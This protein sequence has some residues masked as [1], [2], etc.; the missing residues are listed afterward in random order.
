MEKIK[1]SSRE[2]NEGIEKINNLPQIDWNQNDAAAGDYIKNRT[3]YEHG[4]FAEVFKDPYSFIFDEDACQIGNDTYGNTPFVM[5]ENNGKTFRIYCPAVFEGYKEGVLHVFEYI[6]D[7]C[8]NIPHSIGYIGNPSLRDG[9]WTPDGFIDE[10]TGEDFCLLAVAQCEIS[11]GGYFLFLTDL[12]SWNG[13][14]SDMGFR[15]ECWVSEEIKQLD[16]KF[17]PNTIARVGEGKNSFISNDSVSALSE[18]AHASGF[19]SVSGSKAFKIVSE[20]TDNSDGTGSYILDS[21]NGLD[22][23][24]PYFVNTS[25]KYL[26]GKIINVDKS[27]NTVTVDGFVFYDLQ[28]DSDGNIRADE[29]ETYNVYNY[30]L[31]PTRPD[32]GTISVGFSAEANGYST[33]SLGRA[34]YS[35]GYLTQ[36]LGKSSHAEGEESKAIGFN[37]H[38]EGYQTKA[39]GN[40]SHSEG[41]LTTAS[42][43]RSHAEG[44]GTT[45]SGMR[46][47]AEGSGTIAKGAHQHVQGKYNIADTK[48]AHIIGNG[49]S[50]DSRSNAH[51][52]DWDGNAWYAGSIAIG[53]NKEK[54]L[55][56]NTYKGSGNSSFCENKTNTAEGHYSHAEGN[57]SES[58]G[59]YSHAEGY[60][61]SAGGVGSH[62]EGYE[63]QT[64][65]DRSHAEGNATIASGFA[66]HAEGYSTEASGN[67]SHAE[68]NK[69]VASGAKSHAEGNETKASGNDSHAEGIG[70][71]ASAQGAHAEGANTR[72]FGNFSHA[73]GTG[74]IASAAHQHVQGKY[75]KEV[76]NMVHIVGNG[77]SDENR[78]N[79]HTLDWEGNAWY[80]G[81][82]TVGV[83]KKKLLTESD[84]DT[85][86]WNQYDSTAPDYIKNRT[87]YDKKTEIVWSPSRNL[88]FHMEDDTAVWYEDYAVRDFFDYAKY[89]GK[90]LR[91]QSNLLNE[92]AV[93]V[94]TY[95]SYDSN[96][97]RAWY[98]FS[99]I[100][101]PDKVHPVVDLCVYAP[102]DYVENVGFFGFYFQEY[103]QEVLD[104]GEDIYI[105][106]I[107]EEGE[108]KQLDEKFIPDTIAR[109]SD[110]TKVTQTTGDSE[111]AVMSQKATTKELSRLSQICETLDMA[112]KGNI[113]KDVTYRKHGNNNS[114]TLTSTEYK[115]IL[116]Y[117]TI[118]KLESGHSTVSERREGNLV[119][120]QYYY[121][122]GDEAAGFSITIDSLKRIVLDGYNSDTNTTLWFVHSSA[123][124]R[125]EPDVYY[126]SGCPYNGG[127]EVRLKAIS[128]D[129]QTVAQW[130][131][132]GYGVVCDLR[133]ID[134]YCLCLGI[135]I[136]ESY[137][138]DSTT[139]GL[140]L[141]TGTEK[142][143][144]IKEVIVPQTPVKFRL[145]SSSQ[146]TV[147]NYEMPESLL[148]FLGSFNSGWG[149]T[150]NYIDFE[151]K[152][153]VQT[154]EY[155]YDDEGNIIAENELDSGIG[156]DIS[157]YVGDMTFK[158]ITQ[159]SYTT[160]QNGD[161]VTLPK[162]YLT[163]VL[164]FKV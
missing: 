60:K 41:H 23:N 79:A 91:I 72:A 154:W 24:L 36:A 85:P 96:D 69:T 50:N 148:N 101:A 9:I 135:S 93:G 58:L 54:L 34:S 26:G 130:V 159:T 49:T 143:S 113:Y 87:H 117:G 147:F 73:E 15:A 144:Y 68:G 111:T 139:F 99:R 149:L 138:L 47:H 43:E 107:C 106:V 156:Y 114:T 19:D 163:F 164:Q 5:T 128:S 105:T 157:A 104:S 53:E 129:N 56:E 100:D 83:D 146:N 160:I 78:S 86:D 89:V 158:G 7:D 48:Y 67:Y 92:D 123:K 140:R 42:G 59:M 127:V 136:A 18:Y 133:N 103:N 22:I 29:P 57:S 62:T 16:E 4:T 64:R 142:H 13:Q 75:N 65:G 108:L 38:A 12:S 37:S 132:K 71:I 162:C 28:K 21:V 125:V 115:K 112:A 90:T 82:V 155:V 151:T 46:S 141:E 45:A 145:S 27:S 153:Y 30:F 80:A 35:E 74:T 11:D 84:I 152:E 161:N 39:S 119:P 63:T 55:K 66:S 40:Y 20:P 76:P 10:D 98:Q 110:I 122:S 94:W 8:C 77:T 134:Y 95:R 3:H 97:N 118:L 150:G 14:E 109:V 70:T 33:A 17:I 52:V 102:T 137:S 61:T 116:P 126:L 81:D 25:S 44:S 2:I 1:Y 121:S 6:D 120:T 131:D 32:L 31:I 124:W 51:T 88:D